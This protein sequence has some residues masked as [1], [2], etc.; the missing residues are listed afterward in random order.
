[1]RLVNEVV[2][3][4]IDKFVD[5]LERIIIVLKDNSFFVDLGGGI[6]Y[7]IVVGKLF[8]NLFKGYYCWVRE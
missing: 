4:L 6:L 1:M 2:L 7:G 5:V 8:E 3:K